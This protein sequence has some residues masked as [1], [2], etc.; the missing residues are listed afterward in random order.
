MLQSL[1]ALCN[2]GL[3]QGLSLSWKGSVV[4]TILG[5]ATAKSVFERVI[6]TCEPNCGAVGYLGICLGMVT[7]ADYFVKGTLAGF[8]IGV[9][10]GV[11]T[12]A[13]LHASD[14]SRNLGILA[15]TSAVTPYIAYFAADMP[16]T[17]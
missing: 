12:P 17:Y 4:G 16:P 13:P 7:T 11:L 3:S 6:Q 9:A 10:K 8:V 15:M 1:N 2:Q 14:W 5:I